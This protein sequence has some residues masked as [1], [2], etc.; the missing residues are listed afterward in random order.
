MDDLQAY[1]TFHR[2]RLIGPPA[3]ITR[4]ELKRG[5]WWAVALTPFAT[6]EAMFVPFLG[7]ALVVLVLLFAGLYLKAR[8]SWTLCAAAL[9][10]VAL[11]LAAMILV[12]PLSHFGTRFIIWILLAFGTLIMF[13]ALV[14]IG[15]ALWKLRNP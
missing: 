6:L 9:A 5:F 12:A 14:G 4:Q 3:P 11:A 13:A 7:Q 10:G 8:G 2:N 1:E 15:G